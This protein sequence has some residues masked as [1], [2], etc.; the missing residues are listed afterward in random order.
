MAAPGSTCVW[1]TRHISVKLAG[2]AEGVYQPAKTRWNSAERRRRP[3]TPSS[4][5]AS[6]WSSARGGTLSRGMR[7]DEPM[8][9]P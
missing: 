7:I 6:R 3:V 8:R 4:I 1:T 5:Q 2:A 9:A